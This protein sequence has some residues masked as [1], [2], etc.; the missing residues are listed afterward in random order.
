[1]QINLSN[2]FIVSIM[3]ITLFFT[4]CATSTTS[5]HSGITIDKAVKTDGILIHEIQNGGPIEK[6]GIRKGDVI[7]SYDGKD[8]AD[9]ELMEKEIEATPA[10]KNIILEVM[11]GDELF[12][13]SLTFKKKGFQIINVDPN[14]E[15]P[16]YSINLIKNLLWIGTFP[17]PVD[18]NKFEHILP[19]R[20]FYDPDHIPANPPTF[21]TITVR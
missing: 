12:N 5:N 10:G 6:A 7:V 13:V 19:P 15:F 20:D 18:I 2:I 8:I 17:Y 4:G 3:S 1:M 16:V 14:S 11:R 21:F 9:I